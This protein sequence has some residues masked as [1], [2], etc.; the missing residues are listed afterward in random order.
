ML[1]E[2]REGGVRLRVLRQGL[3]RQGCGPGQV[4]GARGSSGEQ[5]KVRCRWS[6][7]SKV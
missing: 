3:R 4:R 6:M 7:R 5:G 1:G 2:V